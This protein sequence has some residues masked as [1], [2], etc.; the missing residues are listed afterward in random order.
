MNRRAAAREVARPDC[1]KRS[2]SVRSARRVVR[3]MSVVGASWVTASNMSSQ[4]GDVLG[5]QRGRG[6]FALGDLGV[7]VDQ[8]HHGAG[9]GLLGGAALGMLRCLGVEGLDLSRL[10]E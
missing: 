10:Q 7:A 3:G 2:T 6:L 4:R 1:S 9:K 5:E 8:R